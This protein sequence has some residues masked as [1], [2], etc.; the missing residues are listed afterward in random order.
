LIILKLDNLSTFY[1]TIFIDSGAERT[2]AN[3]DI[4]YPNES[5]CLEIPM[6]TLR[7]FPTKIEHC[8]EISKSAFKDLL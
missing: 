1:N 6:C 8:I 5:I 3:S 2:K 7:F 4:Y